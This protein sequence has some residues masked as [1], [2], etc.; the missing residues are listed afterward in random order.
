MKK[1]QLQPSRTWVEVDYRAIEENARI[2]RNLLS[3]EAAMMAVVKS[4][5]YGHGMVESARAAVRG[6]ADW[7]AVD[8]LSEALQLRA[9]RIKAPILVLGYTIPA[10][11]AEAVA[12][13]V[14]VTVSSLESLQRLAGMKLR[15]KLRIHLKFDTGLHRQGI[16]ESHIQQAIRLASAEGFPAVV[17]GAY[18]HF[19]VMEDPMRQDYSKMQARAFRAAVA[20]LQHKGFTPITHASASSGILFSKDFH[21]DVGRAGIAL[22]GLWPS[23]E[24]RKWSVAGS[25]AIPE[26]VP[27]LSWKTIVSEVKL[28]EKGAKVGYDL[29]FEAARPTRLAVIPVGYWHGLPRSLSNKGQ[30]LVCGKRADIVGRI[31]MDMSVIDVTDIPNVRQGDEVVIIGAQSNGSQKDVM[32]AEEVAARGDTIHYEIVTR[33]NPLIPRIPAD[34]ASQ[35]PKQGRKG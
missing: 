25:E 13:N 19:A 29:T 17:E 27:A 12:Q 28:I 34:R 11:Y 3:E 2:L 35:G 22:Y 24:I 7:L 10:L 5:A 31:S 15:K 30:V 6:G 21:F 8:E 9:A 18:T 33:I 26:L 4:N 1:P 16:P 23:P 14:S 32:T 20:R